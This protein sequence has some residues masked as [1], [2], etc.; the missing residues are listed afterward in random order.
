MNNAKLIQLQIQLE[1]QL[2]DDGFL[3][4]FPN[5][6]EQA[7]F[8]IYRHDGGYRT[9]FRHDLLLSLRTKI[10]ALPLEQAFND[11]EQVKRILAEDEVCSDVFI[12]ESCIF[13]VPPPSNQ[14]PLAV[15]LH[16]TPTSFAIKVDEKVV[17]ACN[18]VRENDVC[19][20]AYVYTEPEFR[21]RGYGAQVTAAWGYHLVQ[22]GKVPFYSYAYDN[23]ISQSLT[24]RLNL[25]C[26][27]AVVAY[28]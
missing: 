25:A 6:T 9:Y 13:S 5:S 4:P 15:Q 17:A 21:R 23:L 28:E 16:E 7:R 2:N 14:F 22:N 26:F 18:S 24:Q 3:V 19:A 10:A 12:G 1:Y 27:S 8:I 20:E 11:H